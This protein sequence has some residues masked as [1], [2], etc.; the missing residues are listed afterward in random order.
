MRARHGRASLFAGF[1]PAAAPI[2]LRTYD[3]SGQQCRRA[4]SFIPM[5]TLGIP[6]NPVM[7]PMIGAMI[8]RICYDR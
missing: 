7:A 1:V 6:S 5:L 3:G 4:A 2:E 8:I